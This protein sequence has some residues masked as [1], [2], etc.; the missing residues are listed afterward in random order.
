[1]CNRAMHLTLDGSCIAASQQDSCPHV[2]QQ[3]EKPSPTDSKPKLMPWL[4]LLC[5]HADM[6]QPAAP[7]P[8]RSSA[9]V[10]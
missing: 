4:N 8:R 3:I 1:M 6:V 2:T 7:A 10:A 9:Q 5:I